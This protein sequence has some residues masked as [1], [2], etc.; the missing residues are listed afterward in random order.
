VSSVPQP[1]ATV[2]IAPIPTLPAGDLSAVSISNPGP[3]A[4]DA[5]DKCHIGDQFSIKQVGG[6][7]QVPSAKDLLHYVPLTGREPQLKE[8]GPGWVIQFHGDI[9]QGAEVWTDPICVVTAGDFGFY[10][11]GPVKDLSTGKV[12]LPESPPARPDRTLPAL[13][14]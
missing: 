5:L 9:A 3:G 12:I 14:P 8:V 1:T 10:A 6:M 4:K 11:T 7:G 13:V 2:S